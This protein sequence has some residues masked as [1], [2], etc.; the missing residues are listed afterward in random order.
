MGK[1]FQIRR[2]PL[3]FS[4]CSRLSNWTMKPRFGLTGRLCLSFFRLLARLQWLLII[5]EAVRT[6]ADLE[7]PTKQLTKIRPPSLRAL[8]RKAATAGKYAAILAPGTSSTWNWKMSSPR[9]VSFSTGSQTSLEAVLMMW[10][11]PRSRR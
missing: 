3:F 9:L 1:C 7:K 5:R 10:V 8:A 11:T 4:F 6:V 2:S